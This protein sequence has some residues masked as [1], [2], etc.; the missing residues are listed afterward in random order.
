MAPLFQCLTSTPCGRNTVAASSCSSPRSCR[1]RVQFGLN[2]MPAPASENTGVCSKTCTE[3][4][5]LAKLKA[6]VRPP[7]PPPT[8]STSALLMRSVQTSE[9]PDHHSALCKRWGRWL[10]DIGYSK[11]YRKPHSRGAALFFRIWFRVD[12]EPQSR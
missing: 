1:T 5:N 7:M 10:M 8:T 9:S 3:K 12:A 11:R 6:A 4:P 2:C